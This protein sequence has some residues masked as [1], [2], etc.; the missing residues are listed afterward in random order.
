V[1][2]PAA[3]Q[4]SCEAVVRL[5]QAALTRD[6][7]ISVC[8]LSQLPAATLFDT[9]MIL[10]VLLTAL[11]CLSIHSTMRLCRLHNEL[12]QRLSNGD[13][14]WLQ[15]AATAAGMVDPQHGE[16]AWQLNNVFLA[17]SPQ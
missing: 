5:L 3:S 9:S 17:L 2:L 1:Q 16:A 11:Q 7:E 13:V 4:L 6:D 12:P 14:A 15:Q 10:E 8:A